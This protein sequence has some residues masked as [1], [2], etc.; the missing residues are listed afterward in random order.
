MIDTELIVILIFSLLFLAALISLVLKRI[1][2]PFTV[3]VFVIGLLL[4]ALTA[5][6]GP[7]A[8][9]GEAVA[10]GY[11]ADFLTA[12]HGLSNL[13]PELILFIFLPTLIFESATSLDARKLLQ[14]LVPILTLAIPALLISTLVVGAALTWGL[15]EDWGVN[16]STALLF[17]ALISATDPVAVVALFKELGAPPRLAILVEGESLFNDGTAI[18]LFDILLG[19]VTGTLAAGSP[20]QLVLVGAGNF[21]M[22]F[23]GGTAVGIV[24]AFVFCQILSWVQNDELVEITLTTV[25]AYASFVIA[26]RYFHVSGV[27][28]VVAAGVLLSS[29]GRTKISPP[30]REFMHG[31]WKYLAYVANA[32][33]F[34]LV[35]IVI[36]QRIAFS[37]VGIYLAPLGITLIAVVVARAAGVFTLVPLLGRITEKIDRRFQ[38]IMFWGGLRGAVAL[39]LL[40]ALANYPAIP[41]T[42][43]SLF[44]TLGAGVIMATLLVNALTIRPL[45]RF[46]D[47]DKYDRAELFLRGEGMLSVQQKV[48]A[49]LDSLRQE[50]AFTAAVLE[51]NLQDYSTREQKLREEIQA[52]KSDGQGFIAELEEK[53]F[54]GQCLSVERRAYLDLYARGLLPEKTTK[55]L[56]HSVDLLVDRLKAGT[57]LPEDRYPQTWVIRTA[58][59]VLTTLERA[60]L[61]GTWAGNRKADLLSDAY[62]IARGLYRG[63]RAVLEEI[64]QLRRT[65]AVEPQV[66]AEVE[67]HYRN[68]MHLA[69]E[70]MQ[71]MAVQYPE[72][73]EKVQTLLA[74]RLCLNIELEGY[75]HLGDVGVLPEKVVD[76]M[77]HDIEGR[78]ERIRHIPRS[79]LRFEVRDLLRQVPFFQQ[80]TDRAIEE[81]AKRARQHAVLEEEEVFREGERSQSLY[82]IARGAV[83]ISLA[84]P[85]RILA[86]L[87]PGEFFGEI[88]LLSSRPR[89]ASAVAATPAHLIELRREAV[90]EAA[91]LVPELRQAMM[92]ALRDRLVDQALARHPV[93]ADL[94]R[95]QRQTLRGFLRPLSLTPGQALANEQPCFL[96]V[97]SGELVIGDQRLIEGDIH[98]AELFV[99]ARP[100]IA[101]VRAVTS[102][103][104]LVLG[105]GDLDRLS[106]AAPAI[107]VLIAH[108]LQKAASTMAK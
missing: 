72:Y 41:E 6:Y 20:G 27:M 56:Q 15:S 78:M 70:R 42:I 104:V 76:E 82:L 90:E 99:E 10:G 103:E 106:Q 67:R 35:G 44:L 46:F 21:L 39:A 18:V 26:E 4:G 64:A 5:S 54:F 77:V 28:S 102:A 37:E 97:R 61:V 85:D 49:E 59:R 98:G 73:V 40:L 38:T 84:R 8:G 65:G 14:N 60:G 92:E 86:V 29:Y 74:G 63:C 25:M 36:P 19:I 105:P 100:P 9:G 75:H 52:L 55:M 47:L 83:R 22:V 95:Q 31:F 2:F 32:L 101:P 66:L 71:R 62:D 43:K 94:D 24:L 53:A 57:N 69:Q 80:L 11:L 34:F 58:P 51:R 33:L 30:V 79:E 12:L 23:L 87:G 107:P 17:G 45:L 50:K 96:I 1:Q 81:L 3:A 7:A 13:R 88:A 16:W 48:R 108:R 68:W 93:F 89:T 91:V